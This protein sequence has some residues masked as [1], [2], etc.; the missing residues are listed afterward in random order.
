[1]FLTRR[2]AYRSHFADVDHGCRLAICVL[3]L[4]AFKVGLLVLFAP[5]DLKNE[6]YTTDN[7]RHPSFNVN[8]G[9]GIAN[10]Q[11]DVQVI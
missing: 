7:S 2:V 5:H 9:S 11:E 3:V 10:L 8:V 4:Q 6:V 1:M